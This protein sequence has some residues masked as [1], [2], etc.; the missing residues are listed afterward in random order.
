MG[1]WCLRQDREPFC[2]IRE[3]LG[4]VGVRELDPLQVV[5]AR[6]ALVQAEKFRLGL[7]F[8]WTSLVLHDCR[9]RTV[10]VRLWGVS[11]VVGEKVVGKRGR[12]R[13]DDGHRLIR[14]TWSMLISA[15]RY[16]RTENQWAGF[17]ARRSCMLGGDPRRLAS[18]SSLKNFFRRNKSITSPCFSIPHGQS[19]ERNTSSLLPSRADSLMIST[20]RTW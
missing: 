9:E 4:A 13:R 7:F 18:M 14:H 6:D 8:A 2:V 1:L 19:C 17:R 3:R 10:E 5:P 15:L 12:S 16:T 11:S 20:A